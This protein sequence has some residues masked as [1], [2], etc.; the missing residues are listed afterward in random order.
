[1]RELGFNLCNQDS[2]L[3]S[4]LT[5]WSQPHLD[6]SETASERRSLLWDWVN[7]ECWC[8]PPPSLWWRSPAEKQMTHRFKWIHGFTAVCT[9]YSGKTS[10]LG[11]GTDGAQ[12]FS[13][14][15]V[16]LQSLQ[17]LVAADLWRE[18]SHGHHG[19]VGRSDSLTV[20]PYLYP[21]QTIVLLQH[22]I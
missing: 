9:T 21:V 17:V 8:R 12:S 6:P 20:I 4:E 22:D 15:A 16:R 7:T 5:W 2:S 1:M 13:S 10:D 14:E 18:M 11:H 19:S 3:S